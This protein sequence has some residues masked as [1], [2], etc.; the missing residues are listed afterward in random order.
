MIPRT[1]RIAACCAALALPSL[2]QQQSQPPQAAEPDSQVIR[3]RVSEVVVPVTVTDQSG[4]FVTNMRASDFHVFD[5]GIEQDVRFFSAEQRQP[6]VT[7]FLVD[8]SSASRLRWDNYRDIMVEMVLNLLPG[9]DKYSGYL[10][11]FNTQAEVLVNTTNDPEKMVEKLNK[12]SPGGGAAF[13]DAIY[14]AITNRKLVPG[15][16]LEPRRVI[17]VLGDGHDNASSKTLEQVLELAQRNLVTIYAISTEAYGFESPSSKNLRRLADETGGRVVYPFLDI[18]DNVQGFLSRAT[19]HGNLEFKVGTGGYTNAIL[20]SLY[21]AVTAITGEITTQY[22]LRYV[23]KN[24]DGEK[25]VRRIDV[26][27]D[28]PNVVVRA[29]QYY[30]PDNP[31]LVVR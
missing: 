22:V 4:K 12:I 29:R 21:K 5:E 26:R 24:D 15:E 6:V 3:V 17:V 8:L 1:L 25:L 18:Y 28:I 13:Y 27:V 9:G 11:G 7:G 2:P 20:Q 14:Q 16:P 19:D 10:I 31:L 23:P 30:M